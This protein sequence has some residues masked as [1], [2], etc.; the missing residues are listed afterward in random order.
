[1]RFFRDC[2]VSA[3][4]EASCMTYTLRFCARHFLALTKKSLFLEVPIKLL[5]GDY[6]HSAQNRTLLQSAGIILD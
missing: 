6:G 3:V 2:R 5:I 4:L 1:M